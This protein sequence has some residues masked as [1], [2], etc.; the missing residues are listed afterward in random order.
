[1]VSCLLAEEDSSF[2]N[3]QIENNLILKKN[4]KLGPSFSPASS[5]STSLHSRFDLSHLTDA[6]NSMRSS[7]RKANIAAQQGPNAD[8]MRTIE[9]QSCFE[10]SNV[11]STPAEVP[12]IECDDR[13]DTDDE[14]TLSDLVQSLANSVHAIKMN[15]SF[16]DERFLSGSDGNVDASSLQTELQEKLNVLI[17]AARN[18]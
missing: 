1:V 18:I 9:T 6:R 13:T 4:K 11:V 14:L 2:R 8:M 7:R 3:E 10:S 15:S 17:K 16:H 5:R 12:L